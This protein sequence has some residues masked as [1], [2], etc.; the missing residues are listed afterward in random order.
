MSIAHSTSMTPPSAAARALGAAG[1]VG[2]LLLLVVFVIDVRPELNWI[3]LILFNIGA[4]AIGIALIGR[5]A[6]RAGSVK[7]T[8]AA[9]M[10]TNAIHIAMTV[11]SLGIERPFAG[12]FGFA[13]F[14]VT[15]AMWLA[16]AAFGLVLA[17][18][19]HALAGANVRLGAVA[20]AIG[21]LLAI[22]GMDRIGLVSPDRESILKTFALVGIFLNGLAWI[23]LGVDVALRPRSGVVIDQRP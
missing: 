20:L 13:F 18:A 23:V 15:L 14:L 22:V 11:L 17:G 3:R 10:L 8:A 6:G 7:V 16:D 1:I 4:I 9:V 21:S 5:T 2:G 12:D 19:R